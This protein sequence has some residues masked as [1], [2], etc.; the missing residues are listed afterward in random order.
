MIPLDKKNTERI[1]SL[2]GFMLSLSSLIIRTKLR[3]IMTVSSAAPKQL[4]KVKFLQKTIESEGT[5]FIPSM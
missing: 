5:L 2:F 3:N 4:S 1:K